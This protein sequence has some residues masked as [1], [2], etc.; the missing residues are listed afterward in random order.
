MSSISMPLLT[1]IQPSM[2]TEE[3]IYLEEWTNSSRLLFYSVLSIAFF[4]LPVLLTS[5]CWIRC[6]KRQNVHFLPYLCAI[7][8]AN[9]VLLGTLMASVITENT[10]Y[11]YDLIPGYLVC[12]LTAFLVNSSSCFIHWAWVAMYA[13]RF[14]YIFFPLRFR[15]HSSCR[16]RCILLTILVMSMCIQ[17]WTPIFIT[18]RRLDSQFDNI[19][20]GEDPQYE[21]FTHTQLIMV[22]EVFAT[23]FLPLILTIF[24][25]ISV[26]TWK[27]AWGLSIHLVSQ[28]EIRSKTSDNGV[29]SRKHSHMKI[30]SS[31]S[32]R[33][34]QKQRSNAIRRCLISATITLFLNL[35]NYSLQLLDEFFNLRESSSIDVRRIFLRIDAFV[36]ILYLMQFPITP[37]HIYIL[38][39]TKK[40]KES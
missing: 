33:N 38:T 26:L 10:D 36:Y 39:R 3:Q 21:S 23:F 20:C 5:F 19:Y 2:L 14:C 12:K 6:K 15:N 34:S 8:G 4:T 25:D 18:G 9:M 35:P 31:N 17:L 22:L 28:D 7:L 13:E 11:V 37:I 1:F 32:M 27:S 16:T 29:G 40:R 30:V 24:A